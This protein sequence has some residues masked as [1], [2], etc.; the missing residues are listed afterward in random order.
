VERFLF[1]LFSDP[2]IIRLPFWLSPLQRPL[3]WFIARKRGRKSREAYRS[4]GGGSPILEY[5]TQQADLVK[6][7]LCSRGFARDKLFTYIAMRYSSP[8]TEDALEHIAHDNLDALVVLPLYPQYSISTTGSSLKRL[9]TLIGEDSV[10]VRARSKDSSIQNDTSLKNVP[11][12]VVPNW[13]KRLGYLGTV[14]RLILQQVASF[15]NDDMTFN[16]GGIHILFSAH[17]V[18]VSYIR[19]GDPYEAQMRECVTLIEAEVKR[20]L[21]ALHQSQCDVDAEEEL[22]NEEKNMF[23][24]I[25]NKLSQETAIQLAGEHLPSSTVQELKFHLSFQSRVGP[26]KWL[27][28]YTDAKLQ[29]LG[30]EDKVKSLVVVPISFVSE[31]IETLEEIDDEYRHLALSSGIVKWRRVPALNLDRGFIRELSNI[32]YD[33]LRTPIVTLAD[34]A[35]MRVK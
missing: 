18:P 15:Q 11:Y 20:Q 13:Y 30:I 21:R 24:E 29:Q 34:S 8:F 3:A 28:P 16:K 14:A 4:I 2:D 10:A 5:T 23:A 22:T 26:V 12:T 17:G 33:A 27:S 35:D 19:A 25:R 7:E 31:H 6:D 1:N 9:Q 32:V